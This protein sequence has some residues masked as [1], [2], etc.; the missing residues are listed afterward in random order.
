MNPAFGTHCL[1]SS[2]SSSPASSLYCVILGQATSTCAQQP[3]ACSAPPERPADDL[4]AVSSCCAASL[5]AK[6]ASH[7]GLSWNALIGKYIVFIRDV[8]LSHKVFA[9][10][11]PDG[12]HLVGH[13]L[14]NKLFGEHNLIFMM[15]DEHK[16]LRRRL[17]PLF[18]AKALGLYIEIQER[19]IRQHVTLWRRLAERG[20]GSGPVAMRLLLRDMNLETSQNVFAG[21]YLTADAR[22]RFTEDYG[23]FNRGLLALPLNFPGT[24]FW[25]ARKAVQRIVATLAGCA[26]AAKERM[27]A[28]GAEPQC[29]LDVWMVETLQELADAAAAGLPKPPHSSNQEIGQH[30]FDFLF[31]AQDA[32]TS[33]LVWA[34]TLLEQHQDVLQRVREELA[35]LQ[36]NRDE[37]YT[38][39][40]LRSLGYVDQVMREVL[41]F[42]PPATM[43][44][45]VA[46]V[47]FPLTD[48]YTVPK[49]ASIAYKDDHTYGCFRFQGTIVFPSL[50]EASFQGFAEPHRFDP[51]RFSPG[52]REDVAHKRSWLLFGAGPHQCLGQRYAMNH[53]K[54]F[55]A[56]LC[57]SLDWRREPSP[58][59]DELAYVPTIIP[60]DGALVRLRPYHLEPLPAAAATTS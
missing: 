36:P 33:S 13:P 5:Q 10:V 50:L 30:V 29:L 34:V 54:L 22:A 46:A 59:R 7:S 60:R 12:F 41:R 43:V 4:R 52:R 37:A 47:P 11:R 31:A 53:I 35:R 32:S 28:R 25:K 56:L 16:D 24:D 1:S 51:D 58:N 38:P 26:G 57:T 49:V 2:S 9:N 39:E 15:G 27:A 18:T 3:A 21:P 8:E 14:G 48:K 6:A 45:H 17:A 20:D 42:R 44:P 23:F 55:I 19:T 40:L